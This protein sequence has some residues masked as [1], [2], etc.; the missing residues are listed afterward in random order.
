MKDIVKK[1]S[2]AFDAGYLQT[3]GTYDDYVSSLFT[4]RRALFTVSSTAG[5]SYNYNE[6][7]PFAVG[8]AKIPHPEGKEY[9]SINQGPSVC[10]LD[11]KDENRSLAAYL[12]WKHITNKSNSSSW[13]LETG[14]MGIRNSSYQTEQYKAT[15]NVKEDETNLYKIAVADNLKKIAEVKDSTF[16]TAIFRGSSNARTEAGELM[17]ECL[18]LNSGDAEIDNKISDLF[19]AHYDKADSYLQK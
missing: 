18:V 4:S 2:V 3:R 13:A 10:I 14:Y 11:H 1:M 12:L 19:Q 15:I 7:N 5:L 6:K 9:S 16:N 8:V 17:K